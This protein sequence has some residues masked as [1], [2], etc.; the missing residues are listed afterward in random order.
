MKSDKVPFTLRLGVAV[1]TGDPKLVDKTLC[2]CMQEVSLELLPVING[3]PTVDLP[4]VAAAMVVTANCLRSM[5]NKDAQNVIDSL[6][7]DT[8]VVAINMTELAK[9]TGVTRRETA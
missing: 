3:R 4:F 6:V 5:M 2:D 7:K 8:Q 9:Q 1:L